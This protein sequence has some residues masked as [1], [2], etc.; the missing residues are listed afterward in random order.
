MSSYRKKALS[1]KNHLVPVLWYRKFDDHDQNRYE[2]YASLDSSLDQ[3]VQLVY[4][5][6]VIGIDHIYMFTDHG[7]TFS[8]NSQKL[9]DVPKEEVQSRYCYSVTEFTDLEKEKF[10]EWYFWYPGQ[11][12]GIS[13]TD[14]HL[15]IITPKLNRIFKKIRQK[16]RFIHGGLTFQECDIQ[17]LQSTS[18]LVPKVTIAS[19]EYVKHQIETNYAKQEVIILRKGKADK[20]LEIKVHATQTSLHAPT[21]QPVRIRITV[22]VE[23]TTIKPAGDKPLKAGGA[24]SFKLYFSD[25]AIEQQ[26]T[27]TILDQNNEA[28]KIKKVVIKSP[29]YDIG[30]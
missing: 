12:S 5:L 4:Q 30:F 13:T 8:Q 7:F 20:F 28:L 23:N 11:I 6:H 22:D 17:F 25:I 9:Q 14:N 15:T 26:V 2:F 19:I 21:L 1:A 24:I 3:L 27:I 18:V 29:V 16:E 10:D